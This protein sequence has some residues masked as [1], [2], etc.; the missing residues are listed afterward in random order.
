MEILVLENNRIRKEKEKLERALKV[1]IKIRGKNAEISGEELD[2]FIATK[3]LE[4]VSFGFSAEKA[5]LLRDEDYVFERMSIK[6]HGEKKRLEQIRARIIGKHGRTREILEELSDCFI[7][8]HVNEVG[9]IGRADFMRSTLSAVDNILR[10]R[11]Q[12]QAYLS[13]E[14]ARKRRAIDELEMKREF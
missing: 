6:L 11:K 13:L 5:L 1:K 3:V 10:G 14:K 4:A 2:E 8:I 7:V 12:S 9:I